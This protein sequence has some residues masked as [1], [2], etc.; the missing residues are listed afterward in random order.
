[1]NTL[2]TVPTGNIGIIEASKGKLEFVSLKDYGK[3]KNIKADF[4]GYTEEINQVPHGDLMPYTKKWV[5]TIST[6]YGCSMKCKF[7]DV[8][9]VGKG[10]N[11]SSKDMLDQIMTALS[12]NQEIVYTD[13][14]NIH[15]ARMG[16]PTFNND[17]LELTPLLKEKVKE[18]I[19]AKTVHPV[20]S[21]MLPKNNKKLLHF[22]KEW[23][24]IK[25][26]FYKGEAGLQFSINSTD[27][28]Q[29]N[30]MFQ[31]CSLSLEDISELGKLLPAPVGRKYALNF[32]LAD[33]FI[34]DAKRLKS[35]FDPN[36]FMVKI[37]P[38]HQNTACNKNNII[39]SNGYFDYSPYRGVE[40]S[41]IKEGFD[42]LVFI[43][44]I[45]EDTS[46]ITCG[47]A[48]L[49]DEIKYMVKD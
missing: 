25:N 6:Q 31:G 13:R 34:V 29:R 47:N 20:I 17:I 23:C 41:L 14:L 15:Y 37:T 49:S 45:E 24:N 21:T 42:V 16:E 2:L 30:D 44:S 43:P 12:L 4:L 5:I 33:G 11:A 18:R 8:P 26:N 36:K 7:C 22:L 38:I 9:S 3:H 1:M 48:I 27:D 46:R 10:I 40:R 19:D 35:L 32:A 28:A 39:T